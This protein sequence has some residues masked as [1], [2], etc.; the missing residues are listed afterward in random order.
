MGLT[1]TRNFVKRFLENRIVA[2]R[3]ADIQGLRLE[4]FDEWHSVLDEALKTL[5]E[6]EL[7]TNEL[8]RLLMQNPSPA[9]KKMILVTEN[10]EPVG[11]A[12]LRLRGDQWEPITQWILPGVLFPVKAGYIGRVLPSLG[13]NLQIGWWRWD[14]PPPQTKW[15]VDAVST[16][17]YGIRCS[18][19]FEAY[20]RKVG[21]FKN[22]RK[23]RNRCRDFTLEIDRRGLTE[24]TIRKWEE[25]WRPKGAA[26]NP[27]LNDRLLA[28]RYL[29]DRGLYH[30]LSLANQGEPIA[31]ATVI[32]HR[33]D[34]VG[35]Y[36][37]SSPEFNWHN[38]MTRLMELV[39]FWS[40][41]SGYQNV[42]IGGVQDYKKRWAPQDGERWEF[43]VCPNY[44]LHMRR[45]KKIVQK[46]RDK[47][48]K[49]IR[50][51]SN[52]LGD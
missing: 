31:S 27:D 3:M 24:W 37:Y 8:F 7:C 42:D 41:D 47:V 9:A 12:G 34:I 35:Q 52:E 28:A 43:R 17:R 15:T 1:R 44:L 48:S 6:T 40:Q 11:L 22:I 46:I 19:D 18:E 5:P 38:V 36:V 51:R 32:V 16:P 23:A 21:H 14:S 20:W 2:N 50:V 33:E 45:A 10:G 13:V 30:I 49:K 4:Y 25:R 26:E 29:K 39:F